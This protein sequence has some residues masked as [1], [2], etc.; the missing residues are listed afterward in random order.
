MMMIRFFQARSQNLQ[1]NIY[2]CCSI[3]PPKN[4]TLSLPYDLLRL[5]SIILLVC[6]LYPSQSALRRNF[7]LER[8]ISKN[9]FCLIP[10][11]N[12]NVLP[13]LNILNQLSYPQKYEKI[14]F[15]KRKIHIHISLELAFVGCLVTS[16]RLVEAR[17]FHS[18]V[19]YVVYGALPLFRQYFP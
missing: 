4:L 18:A 14:Y 2:Q 17:M 1:H 9:H 13:V 12:E 11:Q 7:S 15:C 19:M 6:S 8:Q 16:I 10:L 3:D 5:H